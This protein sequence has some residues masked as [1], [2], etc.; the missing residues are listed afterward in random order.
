MDMDK[1]AAIGVMDPGEAVQPLQ[2]PSANATQMAMNV[3]CPVCRTANP[4]SETYCIDCGFLLSGAPVSVAEMPQMSS[5]GRLVTPDGTREFP[6]GPGENSVGRENA[7]VLLAHNTVSR[8][9]ATVT[10]EDAGA[11]VEDAGST[12]GTYVDGKKLE[13]NEKIELADGG[14]LVVGSFS[15]KYEAPRDAAE[16]GEQGA[17]GEEVLSSAEDL[18]AAGENTHSP[19]G[20]GC[21]EGAET[22]S[23]GGE[24]WGEGAA[25]VGWLVAKDGSC[26][27]EIHAEANTIGRREGDNNI[28]VPD[29]YCSGRHADLVFKDSEFTIIDIGSTNG[30]SV[31]GV[32]LEPN[33]PRTL[34]ANDE[35]TLGQ[36]SFVLEVA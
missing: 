26:R 21:G 31:N 16:T 27:L 15:L 25:P 22:P 29:P 4:P 30:T 14:E 34:S 12:N 10:V 35:I 18:C 13:P 17:E 28:V 5:A 24:D 8:R 2:T 6:L 1:T 19:G 36:M 3:E 33:T 20:E 7:D 23:P 9:H 32:R 11:F